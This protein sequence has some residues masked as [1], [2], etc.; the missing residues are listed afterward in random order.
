MVEWLIVF[1]IHK[2]ISGKSKDKV[3]AG[4]SL[5]N[6]ESMAFREMGT[7]GPFWN[8]LNSDPTLKL[9]QHVVATNPSWLG[10]EPGVGGSYIYILYGAP[11]CEP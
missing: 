9:H 11:S 3:P 6:L 7:G 4:I 8:T 2:G 10:W 5:V 1:R